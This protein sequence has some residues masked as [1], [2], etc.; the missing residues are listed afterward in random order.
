MKRLIKKVFPHRILSGALLLAVSNGAMAACSFLDSRFDANANVNLNAGNIVVQR[1]TP[2]GTVVATIDD[3]ALGGRNNF[4]LCTTGGFTTQWAPGS[5][6]FAPVTYGGQ[7]LYQS[8]IAG[9][10]WRVVTNGAG[11]TAGRYGTGALPRSITGLACT[12]GTGNYRLCGG[13]WGNYRLQLVKIAATTGSGPLTA[14]S[15][16]KALV[17]GESNIMNYTIASGSVQT[18]ACSVTNSNIQV[19]MHTTKNS[20]F[21]GMGSTSG[22]TAFNISLNCDAATNVKMTISPGSSGAAD[23]AAGV[24]KLNNAGAADT[25]SGIG[26]QVLYNSAP[27]ALGAL[28]TIATTTADGAYD[29]PMKARY[30]QNAATITPG[31]ADANATFTMTYQ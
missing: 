24:L 4:F 19:T 5:G 14:G 12:S 21:S 20:D 13:T 16:T 17:V 9:L 29:I 31:K 25:A 3:S 10:A 1:D 7:T 11:S 18:V 8:G 22:E 23:A 30:I 6:G 2:V 27:L 26:V 15:I 28:L